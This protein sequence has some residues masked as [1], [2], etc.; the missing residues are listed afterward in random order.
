VVITGAAK[1]I[2]FATAELAAD[3]GA[4]VVICDL[5]RDAVDAAVKSLTDRG[6]QAMGVVGDVSKQADVRANVEEIMAA[7]GQ[8]DALVNNA[9]INTYRPSLTMSEE[10]WERE[11]SIVL[12]GTFLWSQAVGAAAMVPARKGSIVNLGS[13]AALAAIPNCVA[14]VAAKHGVVGLTKSLAVDWG[15][16]NVRVNCVCPGLT[17]TDLTKASFAQA[18]EQMRQREQRIPTQRGAQPIDIARTILFL[19]SYEADAISGISVA[20]DGG[21]M[22]LSS[23][24]SAP[25]DAAGL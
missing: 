18:P 9:A 21:T 19:A 2:G 11:V 24:F 17:F 10:I 8:I 3:E 13:G 14:Y 6:G 4:K 12:K 1:G 16:Y 20:V 5:R 22:A 7:H 15:Q 25:R 23:G